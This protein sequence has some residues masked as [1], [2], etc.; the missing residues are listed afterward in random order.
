MM[1]KILQDLINTGKVRSF[2]D[3]VIMR[4]EEKEEYD[5]YDS[6]LKVLRNERNF[7]LC[8]GVLGH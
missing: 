1:N 2:I 8:Y 5:C 7:V 3:N 6:N 4:T